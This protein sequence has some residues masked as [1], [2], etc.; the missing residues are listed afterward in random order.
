M[1]KERCNEINSY[2]PKNWQNLIYICHFLNITE[3]CT[4]PLINICR[5][6][7]TNSVTFF[8]HGIPIFI[9]NVAN[10]RTCDSS[11]L[12]WSSLVAQ[13]LKHLPAMQET[14]VRSL[15]WED[16]RE[17]AMAPHSSILAWRIPWMEEPGGLQ[18]TGSQRV[19]HDWATSLQIPLHVKSK[20]IERVFKPI[21]ILTKIWN[22]ISMIFLLINLK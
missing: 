3:I 14:W 17:K 11:T 2:L 18:S 12:G 20:F 5:I 13:R 9:L 7:S 10:Y 4:G 8:L 1:I 22:A 15:G 21:Y 16:P 6:Y 19:G